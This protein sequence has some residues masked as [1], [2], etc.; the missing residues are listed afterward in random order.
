M[1][2]HLLDPQS[3]I[4]R[5]T[6]VVERLPIPY[7]RDIDGL[8][9]LAVLCVM[10]F[11]VAPETLPGGFIGVDIFFVISG[12]LITGI[13]LKEQDARHFSLSAFYAARIRRIFPALAV[14]LV[15]CLAAGGLI[16]FPLDYQLLGRE[17]AAAA[18][19]V[20]NIDFWLDSGYFGAAAEL[21]PT[22]HLWSLGVEEQFYLL[23]PLVLCAAQSP[24]VAALATAAILAL[25]FSLNIFVSGHDLVAAFYLPFT[26][27]WE[28]MLGCLTAIVLQSDV[29]PLRAIESAV[30]RP[31]ARAANAVSAA[32]LVLVAA[33]LFFI[34]PAVAFPGWW[35]LMP[36]VGAVL[37]ILAGPLASINRALLG[38]RV[39]VYIG[40]ISYP[41]YL[42]HWPLL[43]FFRHVEFRPA[44]DTVK[45]IVLA[46][47]WLLADLTWRFVERPVRRAEGPARILLP[48]I[49][50]AA[51]GLTG[52]VVLGRNGFP[53]RFPSDANELAIDRRA[54]MM[55]AQRHD[56]CFRGDPAFP[57]ECGFAGEMESGPKLV[58]WG[59]SHAAS[60]YPGLKA[61]ASGDPPFQLAQF[62]SS[63][64][65]P[66]IGFVSVERPA[67]ARV[68]ESV[69][70]RIAA[71]RPD[72]ILLVANWSLYDGRTRYGQLDRTMIVETVDRVRALGVGRIVALGEVPHWMTSPPRIRAD[73][74]RFGWLRRNDPAPVQRN[75]DFLDPSSDATDA[76]MERWF[77]DLGVEY[78]SAKSTLCNAQGCLVVVPGS[79]VPTAFD[80]S[81]LT[82]AGGAFLAGAIVPVLGL[83][84]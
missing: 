20:S 32:G 4:P 76:R 11:H 55:A 58:L 37:V 6:A 64:C 63:G 23:W 24:R 81:H 66:V 54:E 25:S 72:L 65:P 29:P 82:V 77:T 49:A 36:C 28:L 42:W 17:V 84:R 1:V 30:W 34:T 83:R 69:V 52:L 21:R 7:R 38:N 61:L 46:S 71:L 18:G 56:I 10:A 15:A 5:Q 53:A 68:A 12:F 70:E 45:S 51:C 75:L 31:S 16:L 50:V 27:F 9:A 60:L 79:G 3:V 19:F 40:L 41:L 74:Y 48:L 44:N 80:A 47:T 62:N 26:R 43:V 57:P 22:L 59:D 78:I 14:V 33:G 67:C 8:R 73:M 13:I 35:A 2:E 39:L